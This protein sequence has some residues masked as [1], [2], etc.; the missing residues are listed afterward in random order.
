MLGQQAP[1]E[2]FSYEA[3]KVNWQQV[4]VKENLAADS[5]KAAFKEL[6]L[7]RWKHTSLASTAEGFTFHVTD[8]VID[9]KKYGGSNLSIGLF[10]KQGHAFDVLAEF[11]DGRYRIRVFNIENIEMRMESVNQPIEESVIKRDGTF[12][13]SKMV[14]KGLRVLNAYFTEQFTLPERAK[15]SNKKDDW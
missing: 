11:R 9:F 8:G 7:P 12:Y 1:K 10:A 6:I 3:D 4:F 13:D 15:K 2:N 14:N 5:L